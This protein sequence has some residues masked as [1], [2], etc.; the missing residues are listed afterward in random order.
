[1]P[2]H[3][4]LDELAVTEALGLRGGEEE[5]EAALRGVHVSHQAAHLNV[6]WHY[7]QEAP[8]FS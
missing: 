3:V 4:G 5:R 7:E 8:Q 2:A 1:M 6:T